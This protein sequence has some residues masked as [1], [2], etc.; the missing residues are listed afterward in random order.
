MKISKF[1]NFL[2]NLKNFKLSWK[3]EKFKTFLK[4][5]KLFENLKFWI[6]LF[7]RLTFY[8]SNLSGV[9]EEV[10][11]ENGEGHEIDQPRL[12]DRN[13]NRNQNQLKQ[14]KSLIEDRMQRGTADETTDMSKERFLRKNLRNFRLFFT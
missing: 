12:P 3:S 13:I 5:L 4:I 11:R 10:S 8:N 2:E 7:R 6:P 9:T 1:S 14:K